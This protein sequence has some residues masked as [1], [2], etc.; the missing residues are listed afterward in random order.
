[1][2]NTRTSRMAH[3]NMKT[4]KHQILA[5]LATGA[6]LTPLDAL[7]DF[8]CFRLAA[9]IAELREDGWNI[10][11]IASANNGKRHAVYVMSQADCIKAKKLIATKKQMVLI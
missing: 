5:R 3:D 1:M 6:V 11:T 2:D 9:R 8:G 10:T 7:H 4:Q